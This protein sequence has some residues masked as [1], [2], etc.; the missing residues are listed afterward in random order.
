MLVNH[1][2]SSTVAKQDSNDKPTAQTSPPTK[3]VKQAQ[4]KSLRCLTL[5]T[6]KISPNVTQPQIDALK[7]NV[8][9]LIT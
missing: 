5:A 2:P 7:E 3:R 4:V 9:R 6:L 8:Q 1:T